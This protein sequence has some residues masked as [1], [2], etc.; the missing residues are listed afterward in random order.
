MCKWVAHF[1]EDLYFD[2]N[3][4]TEFFRPRLLGYSKV[5]FLVRRSTEFI[6]WEIALVWIYDK[7]TVSF[8]WRSLWVPID[9]EWTITN[10]QSILT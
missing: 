5:T 4:K 7:L 2:M 8:N 10:Y 1:F 3:Y 6:E 9:I